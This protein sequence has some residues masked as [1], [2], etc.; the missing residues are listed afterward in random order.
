MKKRNNR[1]TSI[2]NIVQYASPPNAKVLHAGHCS[3]GINGITTF[4][5]GAATSQ[6]PHAF[7]VFPDV[8]GP[9]HATQVSM[10]LPDMQLDCVVVAPSNHPP[11]EPALYSASAAWD[12]LL[13]DLSEKLWGGDVPTATGDSAAAV[14]D[15]V[16]EPKK[17]AAPD[18]DDDD[19]DDDGERY[20]RKKDPRQGLVDGIHS[21]AS[22]FEEERSG[23]FPDEIREEDEREAREEFVRLVREETDRNLAKMEADEAFATEMLEEARETLRK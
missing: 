18:H 15:L 23:A 8:A 14:G 3:L 13:K 11:I 2:V 6:D 20:R 22:V 12:E 21:I 10:P 19:D 4:V 16:R 17:R 5:D 9:G 1:V 7:A